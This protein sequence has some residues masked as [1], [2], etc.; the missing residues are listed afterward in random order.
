[1]VNSK[2]PIHIF[3]KAITD[4]FEEI[5]K[6]NGFDPAYM[7]GAYLAIISTIL[8]TNYKVYINDRWSLHPTIWLAL[9]GDSG[10]KKTPS[11]K[12]I[13]AALK[14]INDIK[15]S[16]YLVQ[17]SIDQDEDKDIVTPP[18]QILIQDTTYE[19]LINALENNPKG[20]LLQIDELRS[21]F[22][23]SNQLS[24]SLTKLLSIFNSEPISINRKTNGEYVKI[25]KPFMSIL[26]GIQTNLFEDLLKGG[27][28][29]SGFAYRFLFV[30]ESEKKT[31]GTLENIDRSIEK[32]FEDFL[33]NLIDINKTTTEIPI[34]IKLSEEAKNRFTDWRTT[35]HNKMVNTTID[36]E[37]GYLSKMEA[38]VVKFALLIEVSD[39][40]A[41]KV[42][43]QQ[44]TD[45]SLER[46]IELSNYFIGN[47]T[48][49]IN[50]TNK[51]KAK[52]KEIEGI[53]KI[54][55]SKV[56]SKLPSKAKK[57]ICKELSNEGM[58]NC[59][60]EKSLFI[61]KGGVSQYVND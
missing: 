1:M 26:G 12:P 14:R 57:A 28:L 11:I 33:T 10:T 47:F 45:Y 9:V 54:C 44:I 59:D 8:G 43:V 60:I 23:E 6:K 20:V 61:S 32:K 13:T 19:A 17:K 30:Q 35:N 53:R 41:T 37:K 29:D 36:S 16:E 58:K 2:F 25:D 27:R 42:S 4:F 5:E 46:G 18:K 3:P 55:V 52:E 50:S 34:N 56:I 24:K 31:I 15:Y 22:E 48:N 39:S 49:L 21:L 40:I 7:G 51:I 38:Y